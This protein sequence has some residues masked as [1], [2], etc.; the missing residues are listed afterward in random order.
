MDCAVSK[1]VSHKIEPKHWIIPKIRSIRLH[2]IGLFVDK[3]LTFDDGINVIFGGS[4]SGKTT[5]V[6]SLLYALGHN[7]EPPTKRGDGA[8]IEVDLWSTKI[9]HRLDIPGSESLYQKRYHK[10]IEEWDEDE[11]MPFMSMQEIAQIGMDSLS[12]GLLM[13]QAAVLD[14]DLYSLLGQEGLQNFARAISERESQVIITTKD[15]KWLDE[16][17]NVTKPKIHR[18]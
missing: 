13:D 16:L 18:L 8:E 1:S 11:D 7:V 17:S 6:R 3:T 2:N 12:A 4:M 5:I 15:P 14:D 10:T 9:L